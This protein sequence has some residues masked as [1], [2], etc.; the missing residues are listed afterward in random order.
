MT[1]TEYRTVIMKKNYVEIEGRTKCIIM[2][3]DETDKVKL[4]QDVIKRKK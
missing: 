4:E 2:I 1:E 3:R